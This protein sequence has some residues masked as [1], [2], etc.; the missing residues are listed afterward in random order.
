MTGKNSD[1]K[2]KHKFVTQN[3]QENKTNFQKLYFNGALR[4]PRQNN[5][6]TVH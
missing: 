1:S 3:M 6:Y 5:N 4:V 2:L